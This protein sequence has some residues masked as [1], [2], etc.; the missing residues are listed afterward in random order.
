MRNR[1]I[2]NVLTIMAI[3]VSLYCPVNAS[4]AV[5][6]FLK[7]DA[8]AGEAQDAHHRGEIDV[9]AWSW[10]QSSSSQGKLT[11]NCVQD[12]SLTKY[13]DSATPDLI[14]AAVLGRTFQE[15]KLTIRKA[16]ENP[17]EYLVLTM[18]NVKVS[19]YSTGGSG[20]EDR[21][22][23]NVALH[24]DRIVGKYT[25]QK[26]DGSAGVPEEFNIQGTNCR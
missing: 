8:V 20:G 16:G 25:P 6:I 18:T 21:L 13:I 2:V 4:A 19:S 11:S 23:E 22:T 14:T 3:A 1:L 26:P 15:G 12:L 17:I 24:F 9:L 7:L 10:G 5:D